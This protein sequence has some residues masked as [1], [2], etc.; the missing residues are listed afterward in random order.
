MKGVQRFGVKR[1]LAPCY[2]GPYQILARKGNVAYKIQLPTKIRATFPIFHV[3]QLKKY[4]GILEEK[5][6]IRGIKLKCDLVYVEKHVAILDHKE[7]V[8]HNQVVKL[9]KVMWS[10]HGEE[11]ATWERE[12]YLREVYKTFYENQ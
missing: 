6:E 4:L 3:S 5:V 1:K 8:T 10:N 2:V 7:W 11:D 9:Y 12:D